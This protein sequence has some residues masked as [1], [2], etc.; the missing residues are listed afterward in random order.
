MKYV[1]VEYCQ[2]YLSWGVALGTEEN[3]VRAEDDFILTDDGKRGFDM[4]V[5]VA[6][7]YSEKW[8]VNFE[9][10]TEIEE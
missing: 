1:Q 9:V 7:E 10:N 6:K 5:E 8:G 4:A 2:E 3:G